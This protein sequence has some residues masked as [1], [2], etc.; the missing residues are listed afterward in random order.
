MNNRSL[1]PAV[2]LALGLAS[3]GCAPVLIAA[4]AVAGYAVSRDSV[5]LDVEH[6]W[7]KVWSASLEETKLL[8]HLKRED[9]KRGR[10]DVGVEGADVVLTLKQLTPHTVRV[11]V[12]ARRMLLPKPEIAQRL[13][14]G[15]T[16]RLERSNRLF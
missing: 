13:A 12:R 11:V 4:G 6:P 8:G 5:T 2:L 16:R 15:I 10:L 14:L 3:S 7:E 9:P 1:F